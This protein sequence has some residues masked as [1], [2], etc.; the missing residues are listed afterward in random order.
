MLI[1]EAIPLVKPLSDRD[2]VHPV[3]KD[4]EPCRS[5]DD[6]LL[7]PDGALHLD[8]FPRLFLACRADPRSEWERKILGLA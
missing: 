5:L 4:A 6:T 3:L 2:P 1:D 8:G 7:M